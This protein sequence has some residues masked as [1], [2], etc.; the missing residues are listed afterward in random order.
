MKNIF[1]FFFLFFCLKLAFSQ[2]QPDKEA[3]KFN[4]SEDGKRFFQVVFLNQTWVRYTQNN[5][6][7]TIENERQNEVFDI[8]LRRTRIQMFGQ[9]TDRVFLYFQ[10]GQNNFNAQYNLGNNRK[11][12]TF[13][14][15]AFCEYKVTQS[16]ALKIG[17]GLTIANGLSRFS[18]PSIG[19]IM[20]MDVP[21]TLQASVD[22]T[23]EFSRKLS[24]VF[25]GQVGKLDYRFS[26]SNPF[27]VTS[28]GQVLP[29]LSQNATFT[30]K[31][32]TL[33]YQT[34]LVWQFFEHEPHNTPY[35][36]GTFLGK[37]KVWNVAVGAISQNKAMWRKEANQ[38]DTTYQD[39]LL[40]GIE[41]FLDMP[42]KKAGMAISAH[43]GYYNYNFGTNYLRYNG[44]M[45]PASGTVATNAFT[46][47]GATF[48]NA[49]PMFG[50]GSFWYGQAGF[51][52]QNRFQPYVSL[53]S[54]RWERIGQ[55]T[56]VWNVGINWLINQHRAKLSLNYENRPTY[57][58]N[59]QNQALS[60]GTKGSWILQY[61]ITI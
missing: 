57:S 26:I 59:S 20:T 52:F 45:N 36:T 34:Y 51:L 38:S 44:L 60:T 18:Q 13:F 27:P 35:M 21:V 58:L 17:A 10:F 43:L 49:Y 2:T 12:A 5:E 15:D 54:A 50:S 3:L 55:Q 32:H 9:I 40:L 61:Q 7:T 47:V 53:L 39:I 30:Q 24:L 42:L 41:S 23:D 8:G 1:S 46:G 37:K 16:N 14:H 48:G 6:G 22:Q 31:G 4:L 33:Q 56:N 11:I 29:P 28:N 19:T 25:R